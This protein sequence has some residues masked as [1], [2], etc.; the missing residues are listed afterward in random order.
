MTYVSVYGCYKGD[1][2]FIFCAESLF[3]NRGYTTLELAVYGIFCV[4]FIFLF[5][6]SIRMEDR[7]NN[8]QIAKVPIEIALKIDTKVENMQ[9]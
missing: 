5:D 8:C 4:F 3:S 2:E 1:L 7:P 9:N 6:F